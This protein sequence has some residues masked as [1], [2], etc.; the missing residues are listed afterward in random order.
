MKWHLMTE[1][2][3]FARKSVFF[4]RR[5][6]KA[7]KS[8]YKIFSSKEKL[9][10]EAHLLAL[11]VDQVKKARTIIENLI[12][13]AVIDMCKVVLDGECAVNFEEIPWPNTT[14]SRRIDKI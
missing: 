14:I 12:L 11:R 6:F 3:K 5:V 13:T 9:L 1:H 2:P 8:F 7:E 10:K 4:E